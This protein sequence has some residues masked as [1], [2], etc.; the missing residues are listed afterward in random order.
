MLQSQDFSAWVTIE[1]VEAPEY[2]VETS[3]NQQEISCWIPSEVG[4]K[5][6]VHWSNISAPGLTGGGVQVDGH[7]CG[8]EAVA[9][10]TRPIT[11]FMDGIAETDT[12]TRPFVFAPL[13][14]TDDD[15]Y[16]ESAT[17]PNLGLIKLEIW[18]VDV[19]GGVAPSVIAVP[20]KQ[21]V[22]ERAKKGSMNQ[23]IT[24]GAP[25]EHAQVQSAQIRRIGVGPLVTFSFKYRSL[26]LLRANGITPPP[27]PAKRKA[28]GSSGRASA[29]GESNSDDEEAV[30]L[31]EQLDTLTAKQAKNNS[32]KVKTEPTSEPSIETK[33]KSVKSEPLET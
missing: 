26:D 1:G 12:K 19:G 33:T 9:S 14:L 2:G 30:R 27:R 6:C 7:K 21:K 10:D 18:R 29:D 3:E 25:V 32:K 16:L 8:F 20:S 15:A 4:K 23:Q 17:H 11:A 31:K 24:F 28:S 22:H 13:E 5:F